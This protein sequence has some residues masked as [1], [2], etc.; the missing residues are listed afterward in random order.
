MHIGDV[1]FQV[2]L[3][4][5]AVAAVSAFKVLHLGLR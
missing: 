5:A 3:E 4:I 1:P 2:G